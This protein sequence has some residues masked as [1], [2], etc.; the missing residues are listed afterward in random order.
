MSSIHKILM[1][2][3]LMVFSNL[4]KA[5]DKPIVRPGLL[6]ATANIGAG[7]LLKPTAMTLY[8]NGDLEGYISKRV[9]LRGDFSYYFG[10]QKKDKIL[11]MNHSLF[12]G[13]SYHFPK[14]KFDP[15][16][17][18]QPGMSF[19]QGWVDDNTPAKIKAV[20]VAS[21][22]G[23]FHYYVAK[24]FNFYLAVRYVGGRYIANTEMPT[25]LHEFRFML[26]LGFNL[27][28]IK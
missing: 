27:N 13:F 2:G 17:G 20:P 10:T 3:F 11:K 8:I 24:Y 26:G 1:V 21:V 4:G 5:Q 7:V 6:K 22:L 14:G 12:F 15:F 28:L 16:I 23:G 25:S 19:V 9:S 18:F